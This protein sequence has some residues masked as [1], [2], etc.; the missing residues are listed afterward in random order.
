MA[1]IIDS[2]GKG[3]AIDS[4][5]HDSNFSTFAGKNQSITATSH[6][7]DVDDQGEIIEYSNGSPIAVT[8]PAI[9]TVSGSNINTDDFTVTL[10]NIGAGLVT[11][12][13]GS[14]DTFDNGD[15]SISLRQ[16]ESA[17]IQT[18]STLG[19]WNVI[20]AG[21]NLLGVTSTVAELNILDSMTASQ[22]EINYP[23]DKS[24]Y[25]YIFDDMFDLDVMDAASGSGVLS[26]G[27]ITS[28]NHSYTN[29]AGV[30]RFTMTASGLGTRFHPCR[31]NNRS[32]IITL[33]WKLAVVALGSGAD[34]YV[35][36]VGFSTTQLHSAAAI[37]GAWFVYDS[38][39]LG[40]TWYCTSDGASTAIPTD[41]GVTVSAGTMVK[42]KLIYDPSTPDVEF[43]IN[44]SLVHTEATSTEL[45]AANTDSFNAGMGIDAT[46]SAS[47]VDIDADYFMF[48]QV[49]TGGR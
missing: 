35:F 26:T 36:R 46:S 45:P 47:D 25:A 18:D 48:N 32:G 28:P 3:S 1:K 31:F 44:D 17:Q 16:Y 34:D 33:E 9:S 24:A 14:T 11:V 7:I 39:G 27:T 19:K 2:A 22:D 6:T 42:L 38:Q 8:L 40:S 49:I 23:L 13:R 15:T 20:F 37:N 5:E 4:T 30:I 43:Y 41:S 21:P 29:A 12:T 10:K